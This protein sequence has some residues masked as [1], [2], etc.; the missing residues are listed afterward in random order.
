MS[1]QDEIRT[2]LDQGLTHYG[3]GKIQEAIDIWNKVLALA[4][5]HAQAVEYIRFASEGWS[6]TGQAAERKPYRP[7]EEIRPP[8]TPDESQA[9]PPVRTKREQER[10]IAP[11]KPAIHIQN[12]G[13]L[14]DFGRGSKSEPAKAPA[15]AA[16]APD[17]E[18]DFKLPESA[19]DLVVA[20][21]A[22]PPAETPPAPAGAPEPPARQVSGWSGWSGEVTEPGGDAFAG[23][24]SEPAFTPGS[25]P[26]ET[27]ATQSTLP[28]HP[29]VPAHGTPA[30][31]RDLRAPISGMPV[32]PRFGAGEG[33][34]GK[35]PAG[36]RPEPAPAAAGERATPAPRIDPVPPFVE[37][38]GKA[39]ASAGVLDLVAGQDDE[40]SP[41]S[42]RGESL[43]K[44]ARDMLELDD[45]SGAFELLKK[46]VDE[47]PDNEQARDL[48]QE[49]SQKL[50]RLYRY[51]LGDMRR[52]PNMR[53]SGD[54]VI[55]LNLDHRAGFL[56]SMVDGQMSLED[57]LSV[58]GLEPLEG[59]G[60]LVQLI[61]E[62]VFDLG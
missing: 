24:P 18:T 9:G 59:M 37:A 26:P 47:E 30:G 29:S 42:H 44:G 38:S 43:L 7:D 36:G 19:V 55:W 57:I 58:C 6:P 14:Y 4:P 3:L 45:F 25:L 35:P 5:G 22:R 48:F 12:W 32:A 28:P 40:R 23:P 56:L 51:K 61:D 10:F 13:S 27:A 33:T 54:E 39:P 21:P 1:K 50:E 31:P 2:L 53:M 17:P 52:V 8:P 11:S 16:P 15:H 20:P 46:I 34:P 62:K 49:A 60:I 41:A